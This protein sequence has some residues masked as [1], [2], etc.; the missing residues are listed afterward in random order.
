MPVHVF[1]Q[2]VIR[3]ELSTMY[4]LAFYFSTL[5]CFGCNFGFVGSFSQ[6]SFLIDL[7]F[8]AQSMHDLPAPTLC[9]DVHYCLMAF[10]VRIVFANV[11]SSILQFCGVIISCNFFTTEVQVI[12][13]LEDMAQSFNFV[14]Y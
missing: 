9:L 12:H 7:F 2:H 10:V 3:T 13:T 14:Y 4:F 5:V 11:Y 6:K 8:L 1:Q